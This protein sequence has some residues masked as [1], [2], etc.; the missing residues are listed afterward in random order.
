MIILQLHG[1]FVL[2]PDT[3]REM[4]P[5]QYTS[6]LDKNRIHKPLNSKRLTM[7]TVAC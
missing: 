2:Y 5:D 6:I 4:I 3:K 1:L 7:G